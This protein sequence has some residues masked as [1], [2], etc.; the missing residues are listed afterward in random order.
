MSLYADDTLLYVQD[1]D[2]SRSALV[3]FDEFGHF[4]GVQIKWS[5]SVL[6]P[7]DSR[8]RATAAPTPLKWVD[9]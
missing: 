7:L 1:V 2:S 5:K 8:A 4:S 6:F 3:L 9:T